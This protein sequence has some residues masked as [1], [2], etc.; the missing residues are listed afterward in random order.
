MSLRIIHAANLPLLC[1]NESCGQIVTNQL[2]SGANYNNCAVQKDS[3]FTGLF[4]HLVLALELH[5]P[6][7]L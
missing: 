5:W 4:V 1:F 7:L 2:I 6:S 3:V